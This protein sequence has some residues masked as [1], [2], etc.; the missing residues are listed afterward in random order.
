MKLDR[1]CKWCKTE[2]KNIEGRVF[3]NH[4]RWCDKNTEYDAEKY[5]KLVTE[6][7]K[8]H[9]AKRFGGKFKWFEVSCNKCNKS[10]KV[11][12]REHIFPKKGKYFCSQKCS[13]IRIHTEE[14][15]EKIRIGVKKWLNENPENVL[16]YMKNIERKKIFSSK[17]EKELLKIIRKAYKNIKWQS[18]GRFKLATGIYKPLDMYSRELKVIIE[19]DGIYHFKNIY[20]NL[21]KVK[22][23]DL[24]LEQWSKNENWT[25]IRINEKTFKQ[26]K[27][28][29]LNMIFNIINEKKKGINKIYLIPE[30]NYI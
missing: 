4:V 8:T 15:K 30:I 10:F 26:E 12:E 7:A 11:R 27:E 22:E 17:G 29:S 20:G 14:T 23:R 1:E 19:Y 6:T 25:L 18:G 3:S 16:K 2:F 28:K 24:L 9:N 5:S 13:H 21:E